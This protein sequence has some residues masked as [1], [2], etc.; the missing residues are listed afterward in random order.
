MKN[1]FAVGKYFGFRLGSSLSTLTMQC[2]DGSHTHRGEKF[3]FAAG[4]KSCARRSQRK[5]GC[6]KSQAGSVCL[7]GGIF[8]PVCI[9][10]DIETELK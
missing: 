5:R 6:L 3:N 10:G 7:L 4:S 1:T 2:L 9:L 8:F